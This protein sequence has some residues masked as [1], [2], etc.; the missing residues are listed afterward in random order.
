MT[1]NVEFVKVGTNYIWLIRK[2]NNVTVVD[3]GA[4]APVIQY[5]SK[6]KLKLNSVLLTHNHSDHIDG[7]P[8][9][10]HPALLV[11]G[12]NYESIQYC[13]RKLHENDEIQILGETF[14]VLFTPGHTA[15]HISYVGDN[16]LFCGDVVFSGGCGRIFEG[17]AD[18]MYYS[19]MKCASLPVETELYCGHEYTL[20]NLRFAEKIEPDN[21]DIKERIDQ[22]RALIA[23]N[24]A[25]LPSSI[26]IELKTNPFMRCD[27][28]QVKKLQKIMQIEP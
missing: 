1:L 8:E 18:T 25:S 9:L 5:I 16:K 23:R 17:R 6:H 14:K 10:V 21:P 13:N 11:Y 2:D 19:V 4:S 15:G 12:P 3:P 24:N 28:E 26:G 20:E 7:L 27:Q 22:V